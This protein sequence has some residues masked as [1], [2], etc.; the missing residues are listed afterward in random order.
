[1]L[2]SA[3]AR[4]V[5]SLFLALL[6]HK[7]GRSGVGADAMRIVTGCRSHTAAKAEMRLVPPLLFAMRRTVPGTAERGVADYREVGSRMAND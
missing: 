4:S 1:M 3:S 6:A 5:S 2:S 7:V